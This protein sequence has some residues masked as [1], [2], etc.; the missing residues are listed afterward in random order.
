MSPSE[1]ARLSLKC[2]DLHRTTKLGAATAFGS[3]LYSNVPAW[4]SKLD[5]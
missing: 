1:A 3:A 2:A 4:R 5:L